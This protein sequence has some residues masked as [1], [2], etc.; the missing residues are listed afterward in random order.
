MGKNITSFEPGQGGRPKGA[1]NRTTS[2]MRDVM[3]AIHNKYLAQLEDD[4][5]LMSPTNRWTILCKLAPFHMASLSKSE[6]DQTTSGV[7][8]IKV[9]YVQNAPAPARI[10]QPSPLNSLASTDVA[11]MELPADSKAYLT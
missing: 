3:A 11:W 1:V 4:L 5:N 6:V 7:V 2:E 8:S 10:E 9:E